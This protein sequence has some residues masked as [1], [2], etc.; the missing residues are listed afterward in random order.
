MK[1]NRIFR[2]GVLAGVAGGL[3]EIAWVALYGAATGTDIASV[4]SGVTGA[5]SPALAAGPYGAVSGI[6][7]HMLL[8]VALGV[9][10]AGAFSAP[11][12]RRVDG[13]SKSTLV[14]LTLGLV[15]AFNFLVV[16][17]II[18]PSFTTLLPVAVT[19]ASKL[20]FGAGAAATFRAQAI[21]RR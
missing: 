8:A 1:Q 10:V 2:I 6:A 9:A 20:L 21:R 17:P 7:I 13:W 11:L 16:L 12:L 14:V 3:A 19:L 5:F 15:W 4:A 18:D